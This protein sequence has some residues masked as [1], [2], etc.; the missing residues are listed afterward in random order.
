LCDFVCSFCEFTLSVEHTT[1]DAN[2]AQKF[3]P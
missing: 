2:V 3:A 1:H